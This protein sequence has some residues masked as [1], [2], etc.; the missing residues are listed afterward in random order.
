VAI[1]VQAFVSDLIL[2]AIRAGQP[3]FSVGLNRPGTSLY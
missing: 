3:S 2:T 1:L